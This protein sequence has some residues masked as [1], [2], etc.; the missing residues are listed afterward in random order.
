M[1]TVEQIKPETLSTETTNAFAVL[2]TGS[3][4]QSHLHSNHPDTLLLGVRQ[5]DQPVGILVAA[6]SP[7]IRLANVKWLF[8]NEQHRRQG[9]ATQLLQ[10]LQA[11]LKAE[12]YQL[13][14]L[15]YP[16]KHLISSGI[17][18]LLHKLEWHA[19]RCSQI[20]CRFDEAKF[21][22]PWLNQTYVVPTGFQEFLWNDISAH[23]R[24]SVKGQLEQGQMPA[25]LSPFENEELLEP[26]NSLGL[27]Y[28]GHIV[29]WVIT[30]RIS[31]DTIRYDSL[32][33]HRGWQQGGAALRLLC[34]AIQLQKEAHVHWAELTVNV[35][36]VEAT[37]LRFLERRLIPYAQDVTYTNQSWIS[38][39]G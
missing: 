14:L 17:E 38:L 28:K 37:W 35:S 26:L 22:P 13:A 19:P 15:S 39:E 18:Q 21:N 30:H 6:L 33:I 36:L 27:R 16:G 31:P 32:Y 25:E 12:N 11:L 10:F 5:H 24:E 34:H 7:L 20:H 1:Y 29:G 2:L 3:S 9:V 4:Y 8:V 23:D